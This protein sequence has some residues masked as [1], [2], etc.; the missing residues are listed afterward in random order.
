VDGWHSQLELATILHLALGPGH[1][2]R[3]VP[4]VASQ[5]GGEPNVFDSTSFVPQDKH[6]VTFEIV[7]I[8]NPELAF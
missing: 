2:I 3:Y 6:I 8:N 5:G 1:E 7:R 4:A